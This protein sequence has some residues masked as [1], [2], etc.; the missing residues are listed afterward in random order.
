M[1]FFVQSVEKLFKIAGGQKG[2]ST[3]DKFF[4]EV[5][6]IESRRSEVVLVQKPSLQRFNYFV[7]MKSDAK[8]I[9]EIYL[10]YVL[11]NCLILSLK[12]FPF[13]FCDTI[14]CALPLRRIGIG[15][16]T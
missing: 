10:L 12:P 9:F 14:F 3:L 11:L 13:Q 2:T 1:T 5:V 8:L 15:I 6:C 16:H 7:G 4:C